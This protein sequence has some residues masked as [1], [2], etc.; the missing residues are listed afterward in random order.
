MRLIITILLLINKAFATTVLMLFPI[1]RKGITQVRNLGVG[2]VFKFI[3]EDTENVVVE[4]NTNYKLINAFGA[5]LRFIHCKH[6][7]AQNTNLV[8]VIREVNNIEK[9]KLLFEI[10]N[11]LHFQNLNYW[12]L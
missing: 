9:Q 7:K 12:Y 5:N 2:S 8:I 1:L 4:T 3:G 6:I 10:E 11:R